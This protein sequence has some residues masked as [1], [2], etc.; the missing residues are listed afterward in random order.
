[1]LASIELSSIITDYLDR[2]K[3]QYGGQT[4]DD[5]WSAI[6]AITGCRTQQYAQM[7]FACDACPY[8]IQ[9]HRSCGHR[10]C[11]QC[12]YS[13][14]SDWLERQE[15][16]L[17]P[18]NYYMVT[19]TLPKP[20]RAS[21]KE[22]PRV[23]Y[24]LLFKCAV[25]TL[26]AFARNKKGFHAELA[27]TAVLHTHSRRLDYHPHV[28]IIVP[29]GGIHRARREWRKLKGKYLFNGR[30]LAARFRGELL[31]ALFE[32][33]LTVPITP[34]KWIAQCQR[35]GRGL[36]ALQYLSRYL[37][38]G[39]I[40][41]KNIIE[42]DGNEVTFR[43]TESKTEEVKTRTLPGEEFMALVLQHTLPRG[44]RRARDYGFLHGNAKHLLKTIQYILCVETPRP[45]SRKKATFAC[46]KCKGTMR[47]V[48]VIPPKKSI[49]MNVDPGFSLYPD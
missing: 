48:A 23:V 49:K 17:L 35:V 9:K 43:Y 41:N 46:K 10:A 6:N 42:D 44:F 12:Q 21:A 37:Y 22:N 40:S 1:M 30:A 33:G 15:N 19:F 20:L 36:P 25:E 39:V 47:V 7:T 31:H 38:R 34:K 2:F 14:T 26:K 45:S 3:H 27:M 8:K 32:A 28:H 16:K 5:Q 29:A 11:N 24:N 18:V 4:R 13:A